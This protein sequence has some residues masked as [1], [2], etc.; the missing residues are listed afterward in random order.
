MKQKFQK[1]SERIFPMEIRTLFIYL[2][3][4]YSNIQIYSAT[5]T[6]HIWLV[7]LCARP[8]AH[9]FIHRLA[10]LF[11]GIF[12]LHSFFFFSFFFFLFREDQ[13]WSD[14]KEMTKKPSPKK[15]K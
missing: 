4:K 11:V 9:L 7:L 15:A 3:I 6:Q 10:C 12:F 5:D 1:T 13:S 8:A 14:A 2:L